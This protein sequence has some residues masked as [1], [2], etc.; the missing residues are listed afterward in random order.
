MLF[1][2]LDED[3]LNALAE[4]IKEQGLLYPVVLDRSGRVIDGRNRLKACEI[5]GVE[6]AYTTYDGDDPDR[7]ALSANVHRRNLTK[8]QIAM[9]TA[10]A[11][12][13]SEQSGRSPSE[14]SSRSLSEQLGISL[15][16]IGK[17]NVVLQHAPDLVDP[18]ISGATGLNEAYAVAQEN[19]AKANSAE[20]QLA[21]LREEDPELADRV[22]EGDLTLAGAWAERTERVEEDKRQRRV[23][24]RLL[25]EVVPPLA[26]ARGTRTFSRYDPQYASGTPIT[27]ETIAHAM[28]ALTEMDQVWQERD[29]P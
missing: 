16:T 19:K 1:P 23:A 8:G 15:G 25:D 21:R 13:L 9:I 12:S 10:K 17:A 6:P 20:V 22:V 28:T 7:Y 26:Q 24:T 3:D 27:R 11:C 2:A 4:D 5:A 14:Q 18:V 29:L